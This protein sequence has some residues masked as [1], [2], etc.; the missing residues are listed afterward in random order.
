MLSWAHSNADE[1]GESVTTQ[2]LPG[3]LPLIDTRKYYSQ[4]DIAPQ[5][6]D[7]KKGFED[8]AR[9]GFLFVPPGVVFSD[10]DIAQ[11]E[12]TYDQALPSYD[13]GKVDPLKNDSRTDPRFG[14]HWKYNN[15]VEINGCALTHRLYRGHGSADPTQD[16]NFFYGKRATL[17][18]R[19]WPEELFPVVEHP[20]L[21]NACKTLLG[22]EKLSFHNASIA[23]VFPGCTGESGQFHI[24]TPAFS[25]KETSPISDDRFLVNAFVFLSDIDNDLAPVR[26][27]PE[28]HTQYSDINAK[29]AK[30]LKRSADQNNVPQA[31]QLWAELLPTD[32]KGEVR[33]VG[34]KGTVI[35]MNSTVLHAATENFTKD[36]TRKVMILN[37]S[38][39]DHKEFAKRYSQDPAGCARVYQL[40]KDKSLVER[41]FL[42]QSRYI[43]TPRVKNFARQ[44][45]NWTFATAKAPLRAIYRPLANTLK[46]QIP[47]E[48]KTH[49]NLGA[50]SNWR[51]DQVICLDFDPK[52]AEV[53]MDLNQKA[54]LPFKDQRFEGIYSSHC[55]EHLKEEMVAW[56]I[57]EAYRTL[58]PNGI[59][60]IT[61]PNI[62]AYLEAYDQRNSEYFNWLR[63]KDIH[64]LESWLRIIVRAFAEPVVDRYSDDQLLD[65]YTSKSKLEFLNYFSNE[66]NKVTDPKFMVP[67]AHKSWWS[68]EKMIT[69]LKATGFKEAKECKQLET[70]SGV[71]AQSMFNKTRPEMSFFVEARK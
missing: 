39:Y 22:C 28:S 38:N 6:F 56:W 24:D 11:I 10:A 16:D 5:A 30:S 46:K 45:K 53:A 54:P 62:P 37:Y 52:G 14:L 51:H 33:G 59:L 63:G 71:F 32:L 13:L 23:S 3:K 19:Q 65:L 2:N 1:R 58:K 61:V 60:R 21:L 35:F 69:L 8:F 50:G 64:R 29:L 49:L 12:K 43:T 15:T 26:L 55:L 66:V 57:K 44:V 27:V 42:T 40:V 48:Q 4:S 7:W 70:Q 17:G 25:P 20:G 68:A 67:H 47:I 34:K 31:G 36:R 41:T 18:E 9:D